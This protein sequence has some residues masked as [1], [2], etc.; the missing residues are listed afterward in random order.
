M[1]I[2]G[3][4]RMAAP[5]ERVWAL[6]MDPD[7]IRESIPGCQALVPIDEDRYKATLTVALAAIT[8]TYEGTVALSDKVPPTSYRMTV[9]GQGRP[10]FVK[11][12][13]TVA[14]R[15]DGTDTL[16]D[17]RGQV[18]TGGLI[19]RLGQRLIANVSKLMQDRFFANLQGK[20]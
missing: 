6:L 15:A 4:Y 17:V 16:V 12:E 3:T 1:E 5:P 19:A 2:T 8:G 18:Q 13:A 14:L 11:G 10:G 7:V 9:E 20:L